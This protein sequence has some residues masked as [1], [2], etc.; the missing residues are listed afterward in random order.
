MFVENLAQEL[1]GQ[2]VMFSA[3]ENNE[4]L[5]E[6]RLQLCKKG[7]QAM[8]CLYCVKYAEQLGLAQGRLLL[9][10]H[11]SRILGTNR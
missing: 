6:I 8:R 10:N 2:N 7:K 11:F 4:E 9:F 3:T 5:R 1:R